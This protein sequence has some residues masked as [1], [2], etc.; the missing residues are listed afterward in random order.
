MDDENGQ[1]VY[2]VEIG[3]VDVKV[4]AMTGVVVTVESGPELAPALR[5]MA[6]PGDIV[7]CL[8]AGQSTEWAHA[9]P[10]W[11]KARDLRPRGAA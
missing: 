7:V 2:S 4:D 10:D 6:R 8:G 9:L 5:A 1:L 11:L 3:G